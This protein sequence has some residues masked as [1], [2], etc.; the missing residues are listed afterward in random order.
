[1]GFAW[2]LGVLLVYYL[3]T[4]LGTSL[5]ERGAV[6]LELGMWAPN[7]LLLALGLYLLVK[8]ARESPVF[9]IVFLNRLIEKIRRDRGT[10]P[11]IE[12]MEVRGMSTLTRYLSREFIQ[13][14][15]LCLGTF[16]TIY[17]IVEFFERINAFL[18]NQAPLALMASYFLEQNS[19]DCFP[20]GPG[21]DPPVRD[22]HPGHHVPAQ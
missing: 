22:R 12:K 2:S 9:F 15:F 3:M 11:G 14:F 10:H 18:Y 13:N 21:R 1:M 8:A 6:L 17:L 4:N 5:A 20:G 7:A 16:A 19:R